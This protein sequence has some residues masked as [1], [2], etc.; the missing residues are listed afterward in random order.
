MNPAADVVLFA[1]IFQK[2]RREKRSGGGG[3]ETTRQR[4][5]GR[6]RPGETSV[7]GSTPKETGKDKVF[8]PAHDNALSFYSPS[9]RLPTPL[10]QSRYGYD[11][12]SFQF[13]GVDVAA[14]DAAAPDEKERTAAR[15]ALAVGAAATNAESE[16]LEKKKA[17]DAASSQAFVEG[18][19]RA[20]FYLDMLTAVPFNWADDI[21]SV[22][23]V[24]ATALLG[25]V[26]TAL[27][28]LGLLPVL[29]RELASFLGGGGDGTSYMAGTG[30]GVMTGT[31]GRTDDTG[32]GGS[33]TGSATMPSSAGFALDGGR[34]IID[35]TMTMVDEDIGDVGGVRHIS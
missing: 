28:T 33:G 5:T 29:S 22:L 34:L 31:S 17:K 27:V 14:P 26:L 8:H 15:A 7:E 24:V 13:G 12:D 10:R 21:R 19:S 23:G 9:L 3:R 2:V 11:T 32:S 20:H 6:G 18:G 16:K 25:P 4:K 35:S 1:L 30:T